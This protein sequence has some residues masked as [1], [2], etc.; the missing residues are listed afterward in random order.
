MER[1]FVSVNSIEIFLQY[2]WNKLFFNEFDEMNFYQQSLKKSYSG[3][4][5]KKSH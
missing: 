3:K 1:T 2:G 4:I 5:L